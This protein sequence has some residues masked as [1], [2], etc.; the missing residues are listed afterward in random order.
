MTYVRVGMGECS[1]VIEHST[2]HSFLYMYILPLHVFDDCQQIHL[3]SNLTSVEGTLL[4][5]QLS[6]CISLSSDSD[7]ECVECVV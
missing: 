6:V 1:H 5:F 7:N 2:V 4:L 3:L